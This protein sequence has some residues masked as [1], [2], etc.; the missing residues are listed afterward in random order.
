MNLYNWIVANTTVN[1]LLAVP[2][3]FVY[4]LLAGIVY[5]EGHNIALFAVLGFVAFMFVI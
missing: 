1:T 5:Y 4:A 2:I 3:F